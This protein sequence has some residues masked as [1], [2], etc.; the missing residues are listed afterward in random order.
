MTLLR[1]ARL[2]S[3]TEGNSHCVGTANTFG[4]R[5]AGAV[6]VFAIASSVSVTAPSWAAKRPV[7]V[8]KTSA[9]AQ[10]SKVKSATASKGQQDSIGGKKLGVASSGKSKP[11]KD[12]RK[13]VGTDA[14]LARKAKEAAD[15][16]AVVKTSVATT[17]KTKT[18]ITAKSETIPKLK[19]SVKKVTQATT[20]TYSVKAGDSLST[21]ASRQ[22]TTIGQLLKLNGLTATSVLKIDQKLV[23]PAPDP[24][25]LPSR[26]SRNPIRVA[27][28]EHT[29][30]WAKKNNIPRDLL[31]AMLWHESGFDQTK[32]SSTGAIGVGQIMPG[33]A[34]FIQKELIGEV[35]NPHVTEQNVRMS[36]RY[37]RYL[38][39]VS[40]GDSNK[41][42]YAYYQGLGSIATNGLYS[43]TIQYARN[44]QS[45]RKRFRK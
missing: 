40:K 8:A 6:L 21:I 20:L 3:R 2:L 45:L 12:R 36:A 17:K 34:I 1:P 9:V 41:A 15:L 7:S 18:K 27:V 26:L 13:T 44:I 11:R 22:Q 35:L 38:L 16:L 32:V 42:L 30:Y 14:D 5:L 4:R 33:T 37:L 29:A 31:E 25:A 24:T 43:D 39:K 28:R 10:K 19:S 23:V